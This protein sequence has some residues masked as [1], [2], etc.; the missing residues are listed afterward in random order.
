MIASPTLFTLSFFAAS[1]LLPLWLAI[2]KGEA[3]ASFAGFLIGYLAFAAVHHAVHHS[4]WQGPLMRYF[5][6]LHAIHHH[7]N[8]TRNF[9]VI[10]DFWDRVFGTYSKEMRKG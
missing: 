9:G 3:L 1:F 2:G 6:R 10:T 7:G 4:A 5:K 8:S